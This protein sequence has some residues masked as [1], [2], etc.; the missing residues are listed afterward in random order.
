VEQIKKKKK[1]LLDS[2]DM[3]DKKADGSILSPQE[4]D[5]KQCLQNR[6]C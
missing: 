5:F 1:Q 2:F 3:L 6:L 4:V